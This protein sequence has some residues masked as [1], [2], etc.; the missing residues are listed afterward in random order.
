MENYIKELEQE[1]T[2]DF[3]QLFYKFYKYWYL[4]IITI[5][6]ALTL[7]FLF[8]KYTEPIYKVGTTVMIKDDK[9]GFDPQ[10]MLGL[11]SMK[12]A[13]N[14]ENEIG[15]LK[16]RSLVTRAIRALN[17][18]V[19][20]YLEDNFVTRELY[21]KSPFSVVFDTAF[22]QPTGLRYQLTILPNNKFMLTTEGESAGVY[23]Y[24]KQRDVENLP[25]NLNINIKQEY[26][27]GQEIKGDY[28]N[29]MVLL[30]TEYN[31][32]EHLNKK[33]I[34]NFNKT[35][36]LVG[37]FSGFTIEPINRESSIVE[38]SMKNPNSK[39]AADFLNMLTNVYLRRSL[40]K[41]NQIA[42]NTI[43]FI[44][45]QLL[46][47]TDS[48]QMA[49]S[50][51]Q[52]FRTTNEVMNFDFQ[53]EQV[54]TMMT[55]LENK[56]AE[57]IVKNKYYIYL[58]NYIATN[59]K[60]IDGLTVPSS[61]GI[62]DPVLA[63][64]INE[65]TR[66]Y[67]EKGE[68]LMTAR[69]KNPIIASFDDRIRI[70]KRTLQENVKSIIN[71]STIAIRDIDSRINQLSSKINQLPGTQRALF[72]IERKFKLNDAIYTFLLEKR[73]EAQITRAS[74]MSDNEVID[75]AVVDKLQPVFPKKTLNY[76]IALLLGL[77]FPV[78]YV[79][80]KDYLNDKLQDKKDIEKLTKI[81]ML[82]H[83]T[84]NNKES[85]IVVAEYPKSS[86][87]ESFRLVRTNL[88]FFNPGL[89][90]QVILTT[91]TMPNEGKTF[92]SMNLASIFALYG[93][94]TLLMGYDLRKPKIYQDFGLTNNEGISS[95]LV[96]KADIS[97]IIQKTSLPN[98][99]VI[100]AG[101]VPPNPAEL[102]ASSKNEELMS[103]LRE[104]YDYII[105]DTPPVGLVTD[106]F[107]MM[108]YADVN[109]FVV[110]HNYTHKKVFGSIISDIEQR[111][112]SNMSI[113]MNDVKMDKSSYGSGYGY[114]Y[115]H[116]YGYGYGYGHGYG[117]GYYT[118]DQESDKKK[119]GTVDKLF[120]QS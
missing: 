77:I 63:S 54:F 101:P 15:V 9:S 59:D 11:G 70:N 87:A 2:I 56:K 67:A 84:H 94:K 45:A 60:D 48:L 92:I 13:Q 29:F 49:E 81:P 22:P 42:T 91:S 73:S 18:N 8:N 65:L 104:M 19:S 41:K 30:N 55:E 86:I 57:L 75:N 80:G 10:M 6:T 12:G 98:L 64:L 120:G 90:K 39:K 17:F 78:V 51:L 43:D 72:G 119:K 66:L 102:I 96:N 27:F 68:A 58:Q 16:S 69:E 112:I 105:L 100:M 118:D 36:D 1:E 40:E 110:R 88:G 5:F 52:R 50:N 109:I 108:K 82:G 97:K 117:Y 62:D 83:I 74:N 107:L 79:L 113:L 106:A 32:K 95:Y 89:E 4:F 28:Y 71:T 44:D 103:Q 21:L 61:M 20:Y 116:G 34:F 14:L 47:I 76:T 99:D 26:S 46:G 31:P 114:G 24:S 35:A 38:I 33:F 37:Q 25:E 115:G 93:K 111:N 7:A 53:T 85:N 3:K 23:S